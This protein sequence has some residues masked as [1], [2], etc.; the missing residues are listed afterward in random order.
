[1]KFLTALAGLFRRHK[2]K[3]GAP[4]MKKSTRLVAG[5]AA[6]LTAAGVSAVSLVG[7][8]E[9]LRLVAYQDVIGVWTA[10]YG[11]TKDIKR[12]MRFTRQQ[13]DVMFIE[14]LQEFETNMRMCLKAPDTIPDG[15]YVSFLSLSYNI[16]WGGFCKSSIARKA[17]AGDLRGACESL[18]LYN[19]AGKP[20]RVVKGLTN[21]RADERK[22]CLGSLK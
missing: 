21:R 19:K 3:P 7:G 18:M 13:C 4:A 20:L 15:A 8:W 1:M 12:G 10:C 6:A 2:P 22:L 9:G 16:G 17:N 14:R 5:A 11:E